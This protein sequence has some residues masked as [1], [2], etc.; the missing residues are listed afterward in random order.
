MAV[1]RKV[2]EKDSEI[3]HLRRKLENLEISSKDKDVQVQIAT[4]GRNYE[5]L[6]FVGSV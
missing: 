6:N 5:K 2:E 4:N 1:Y 3:T